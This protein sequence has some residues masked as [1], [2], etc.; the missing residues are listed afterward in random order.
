MSYL[1]IVNLKLIGAISSEKES[2]DFFDE[3]S[4]ELKEAVSEV[5]EKHNLKVL[6][7]EM[8]SHPIK[9]QNFAKCSSCSHWLVNRDQVEERKDIDDSIK[10]G[11][12]HEEKFLCSDCL[13]DDHPWNWSNVHSVKSVR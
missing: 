6:S 10:N 9:S 2:G 13:P 5:L 11:V 8:I 4:D 3:V 12:K 7:S 1:S